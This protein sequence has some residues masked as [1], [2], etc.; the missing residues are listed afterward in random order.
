MNM[1][2]L[3]MVLAFYYIIPSLIL[4]LAYVFQNSRR[5]PRCFNSLYFSRLKQ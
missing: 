2:T 4:W 3:L 5:K 1:M